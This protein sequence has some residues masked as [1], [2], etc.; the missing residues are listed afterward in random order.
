VS[1]FGA[2]GGGKTGAGGRKA[3]EA[4][5]NLDST[6]YAKI[7][8]LL[9]EGEIEGFATPSRLGLTQGT[10]AYTNASLKDVFFNKT[11]LLREGASN[12]APQDADFN[13]SNVTLVPRFGTQAQEY[14]P[15]FDAVE[16]EVAVGSDVLEGL[17]ITRTI[18]DT[19][20]DAARITINVP[21]LQ[22]VQ[23][24]GDILGAEINLQIAVQY[25]SG[26]FTTVIDD[27]IKGRTSDLYQRDYIITFD[28]A[29]PIDIRITRITPD[30]T[31]VKLSNAFS[32]FS[33]TELIYQ[34]LRYPNSAYV[35][36]RIDAEQFSSIPS[37]SY[38]IRGI[39]VRI[40]NN[41]TVDINT[42]RLTY[43]GVW[44]GVFGAAA[45]TTDPAWI[46]WD[47]LTNSRLGLGDHIQESTLDKWA[48]FQASKYASELV[49]TGISSPAT[50][51]RF[52][53]NVNIQT[54]EEAYKLI[55]DMC[56]VFRAMP[57]WAAGSLTMM[58][59]RPA[60]PTA[61]FSL[62]NVSTE[63]FNYEGSSLKTR[64]T[65]VIVGWLNL[66]LGDI[67]REVV[68]D[69]EGISKYGVITK[70][71]SAFACTSRSQAH[72]IGRWLLYSERY[73]GEVVAFTTS[74]ENGIIVRP[75]AIIEIADPVKAGVRRA[76]R[77]S[78]ATDT[79]L[80][81]DSDVDLPASGTVSVVLPDGIV[82]NRTI[83]SV[84]GTA[85]TVTA[86]FTTAPQAG[87]MWL[88]DGGAVQ[89]TTWR[90]LGI[91]E[92][93]GTN[94]SVTAI[95]YDAGKYANVENGE[96]LQPRS[97]S[98]LNVPPET[99]TDL[100][101]TE[102]FYVLNGRVATKLSLTWKGV[103]GVNEYR[104]RWREEFGNWTEV[105]VYGPLYEI[106]DVVDLTYQV[107]VYAISAT[108]ILSSAPAL[109]TVAVLGVG[110]PPANVTGVS[111]VP[112]NESTAIIQWDLATDLDVLVGG[113]VLLRHDPRSLAAGAEWA[114][115]NA[116]VQAA[117]GNQ[118]Q[119]QVPLLEG[120]YFIAFRDQSG[121]RSVTPVGIPAVLP[122]P[123][124]RLVVKTWAEENESPKFNGGVTRT[125]LALNS[126]DF[127]AATWTLGAVTVTANAAVSPTGAT[128]AD[129]LLETTANTEHILYATATYTF[130]TATQS[131]YVKPNGRTNVALR[132]YHG[133]NDWVGRVFSLTGSGSVTQSSAGSSSGFSAVS[134]SIA[135]AGNGWYRI[136]MT[137]T[138]P[139]RP[140]FTS[141]PDLC[142]SSTPTL[143]ASNGSEVYAGDVT[144]GVYVWGAQFETGSTAS[145]YIPTTSA[146]VSVTDTFNL[147]YDA[148]YDALFLDPSVDLEGEYIYE[149]T[150]DLGQI[151]D[152]N[153]RRRVV[154]GAVTFGTLFDSVAGLFDDQ[155]GDFDGGEL[156]QVNAVTYVRV[157]D[158]DP[159]GMPT[160]SD[161][162]EY[163]NAIV[164][165]RGIQLKVEGSTRTAQV[166]LVISE[167]GATAELQQR[168]ETA[169]A[170]G[171]STYNVTYADAFYAAPDVNISPSNMATGDF[172][173]L[174][175]VTRTGFTVAFSNSASAAVTRSFTYTAVGFGREI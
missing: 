120:T 168:T 84:A 150:L 103:R 78:S 63:G 82:E 29:F 139:S 173:T 143:A 47:L 3:T 34:K 37:R 160:W 26:G 123:Q 157:T 69:F 79:V 96:P 111:L 43:A 121:V 44:S 73:E 39:K 35:A 45:W 31:S 101:S 145:S 81:V 83:S 11:R 4:K 117:A 46:L 163:A 62:A 152:I 116:I 91:T 68:E 155:P 164:R 169:S 24:N 165:G 162:N 59:D 135:D 119:K 88:V 27:T 97:I 129:S 114:A 89:P 125:N 65:V 2:G 33:Y 113:E 110:A 137:V 140:T 1:I 74:L 10:T 146:A 124:P 122:T 161:W 98:V 75:G 20:I 99:P 25:N 55:N 6:S 87:A 72:R 93:D 51:P 70:E 141:S 148:G 102:L 7:I 170:S 8:E 156:D 118:T 171:S 76:G 60:D 36:L 106:E 77:L 49:A 50:E 109:L 32:W 52:S 23:D 48:F 133:L 149:D 154:S 80:T 21:L 86:A 144:K 153:V 95:S 92:Q 53:C 54:Q 28:G 19:N 175:S 167:L 17:P 147:G 127:S 166:G 108:Q 56:S 38:R 132:F 64:A 134:G 15:G 105:K 172:F 174:T 30:S 159:A 18:T 41:A 5:D 12:T 138:Q 9:S 66:D 67:D 151:Y 85:I 100:T 42:G 131:I 128:T 130:T 107:E 58:Q 158:D 13:F 90:V 104:I 71:V 16:E 94:Y 22:T 57:F 115:S 61:L 40:P 14:V 112:I 126:E 142:T 136:S